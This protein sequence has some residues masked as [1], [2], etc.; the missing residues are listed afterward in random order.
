MLRGR[1]RTCD[2]SYMQITATMQITA[3]RISLAAQHTVC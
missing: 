3:M 2:N 1:R